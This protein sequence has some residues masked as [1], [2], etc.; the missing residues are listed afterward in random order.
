MRLAVVDEPAVVADLFAIQ[1]ESFRGRRFDTCRS[2]LVAL[3]GRV[4][5]S[6]WR[7]VRYAGQMAGPAWA[8]APGPRART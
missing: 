5:P 7:E 2:H 4:W 8:C 1:I 6:D 3:P